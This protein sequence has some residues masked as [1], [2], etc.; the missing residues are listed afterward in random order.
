[1]NN[2]ENKIPRADM[3][4]YHTAFGVAMLGGGFLLIVGA[5]MFI[6]SLI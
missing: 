3:K 6:G 5:G 2:E 1:M 4:W